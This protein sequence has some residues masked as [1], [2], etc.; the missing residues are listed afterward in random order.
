M[1]TDCLVDCTKCGKKTQRE[2][3][4][5][6]E[7]AP[8]LWLMQLKRFKTVVDYKTGNMEKK[9]N[10]VMVELKESVKLGEAEYDL[11]GV[12]NHY[13]EI[14]KGHY[15]ACV[16]RESDGQWLLYDDEKVSKVKFKDVNADCA[17][18]LFYVRRLN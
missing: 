5:I 15:T 1:G 8:A 18:I 10:S 3:C 9:K 14:D 16:R 11:F 12:V 13:G 6:I 7:K 2:V 17:Y 4:Y